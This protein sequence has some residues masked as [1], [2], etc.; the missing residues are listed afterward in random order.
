MDRWKANSCMAAMSFIIAYFQFFCLTSVNAEAGP[1]CLQ[2]LISVHQTTFEI[3]NHSKLNEAVTLHGMSKEEFAG[4]FSTAKVVTQIVQSGD[5]WLIDGE[6]ARKMREKR[7]L[8]NDGIFF[9]KS[10]ESIP[11]VIKLLRIDPTTL[12]DPM[13]HFPSLKKEIA[14]ATLL[15]AFGGPHLFRF[16]I[17]QTPQGRRVFLEIEEIFPG[18]VFRNQKDIRITAA[19]VYIHPETK[20]KFPQTR[21]DLVGLRNLYPFGDEVIVKIARMIIGPIE[22]GVAP[23]DPDF[24]L[25]PEG[26]VRWIDGAHWAIRNSVEK[27]FRD[28]EG[29]LHDF[30]PAGRP[31][32]EPQFDVERARLTRIFLTEVLKVIKH[33]KVFSEGQKQLFLEIVF[34]DKPNLFLPDG[35]N[36][37]S[38]QILYEAGISRDPNFAN[39]SGIAVIKQFYDSLD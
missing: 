14:N 9:Y 4:Y 17:A 7:G 37:R 15:E 20:E 32:N 10:G 2:V 6:P 11:R 19:P 5:Q 34:Q 29:I 13:G 28:Y 18:A 8:Q 3:L 24:V 27:L 16:G 21:S 12:D 33:S 38:S 30:L 25:S 1:Q 36:L 39:V 35:S 26:Q 31:G 23:N 22:H